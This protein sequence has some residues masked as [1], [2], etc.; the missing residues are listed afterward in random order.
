MYESPLVLK[1]RTTTEI[2][3][4]ILH[5][6][7]TEGATRTRIMYS[8]YLSYSQLNEYLS[9]LLERDLITYEPGAKVYRITFKGSRYLTIYSEIKELVKLPDSAV[10]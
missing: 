6:L 5:S 2:I 9:A 1:Y 10:R 4:S 8:S 3:D 7:G